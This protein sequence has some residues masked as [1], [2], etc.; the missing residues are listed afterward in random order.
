[1]ISTIPR[2]IGASA[3]VTKRMEDKLNEVVDTFFELKAAT[4]TPITIIKTPTNVISDP[5][6]S[7]PTIT[8]NLLL[9]NNSAATRRSMIKIRNAIFNILH[10]IYP[11]N[12]WLS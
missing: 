6:S 10:P 2:K 7:L 11:A 9:I 12:S 4:G 5:L 1:M 3:R 8:T